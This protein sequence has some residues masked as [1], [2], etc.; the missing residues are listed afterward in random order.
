VD[1]AL[2]A[3]KNAYFS[4]MGAFRYV[5]Q[6]EVPWE[7]CRVKFQSRFAQ[8]QFDLKYQNMTF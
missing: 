2:K 7:G 8:K 5:R 4:F 3:S 1:I 6:D